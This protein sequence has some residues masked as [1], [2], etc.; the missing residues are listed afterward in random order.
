MG[1]DPYKTPMGE[2]HHTLQE[3]I[4]TGCLSLKR[5]GGKFMNHLRYMDG[6]KFVC[7]SDILQDI[8]NNKVQ[9]KT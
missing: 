9:T 8:E 7:F 3:P 2:L 1:L 6:H 5:F 4:Q